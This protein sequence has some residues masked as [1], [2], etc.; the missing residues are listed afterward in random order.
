MEQEERGKMGRKRGMVEIEPLLVSLWL[1]GAS[2]GLMECTWVQVVVQQLWD[3][4]V[5]L[6]HP[7]NALGA[8]NFHPWGREDKCELEYYIN[9]K[10]H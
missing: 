1:S 10:L 8:R 7:A 6:E 4:R 9:P 2:Q 3:T 5:R